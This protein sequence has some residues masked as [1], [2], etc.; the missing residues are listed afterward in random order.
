MSLRWRD[1]LGGAT[2]LG[3]LG[4]WRHT[5]SKFLEM[6]MEISTTL[7]FLFVF[8]SGAEEPA[9]IRLVERHCRDEVEGLGSG[10]SGKGTTGVTRDCNS[11]GAR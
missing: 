8:L 3:P 10:R 2:G 11:L 9:T 5:V 4:T 1:G 6:E 7:F